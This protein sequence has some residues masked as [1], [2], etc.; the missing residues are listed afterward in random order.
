MKALFFIFFDICR[1]RAG[2]QTLPSSPFLLGLMLGLHFV[3]GV[4]LSIFDM[5][6]PDALLLAASGTLLLLVFI[7]LLLA[8]T[9]KGSRF[10]QTVTAVAGCEVLLGVFILPVV[11][12][13]YS[14][15][16]QV[17]AGLLSLLIVFWSVAIMAHILRH[18]LEVSI[19]TGIPLAIGYLITGSWVANLFSS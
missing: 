18:A 3:L 1:L 5:T 8:V 14:G 10:L 4:L 15:A 7:Y 16:E 17:F 9:K 12:W 13:F 6:M 2:P 11:V 19:A